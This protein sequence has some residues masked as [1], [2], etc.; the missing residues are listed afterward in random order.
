M[1]REKRVRV[2]TNT[3]FEETLGY[4]R[5][6]RVGN[7]V[8]LSG[9]APIW[10]EGFCDAD[11]VA[12]ARRCLEIIGAALG[13]ADAEL[14]HVVRTRIYLIDAADFEAVARV[15]AEFFGAVRPAN[16]TVVVAGLL[17]PRWKL[18]IEAE[19]VT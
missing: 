7:R 1:F 9:C 4:S 16:T 17:D 15:H 13:A 19:A 2:S 5:A 3:P 11:V 14:R 10:T 12:Q 6:I 8:I 18:E